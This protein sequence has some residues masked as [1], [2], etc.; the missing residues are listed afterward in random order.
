MIAFCRKTPSRT[1]Y[2]ARLAIVLLAI[3]VGAIHTKASSAPAVDTNATS[4]PSL[5]IAS[6][7]LDRSNTVTTSD[8]HACRRPSGGQRYAQYCIKTGY[9][10]ESD[11]NCCSGVCIFPSDDSTVGVCD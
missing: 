11:H 6:C 3:C 5:T 10:C 9:K 1:L 8:H 7:F 4:T 2:A